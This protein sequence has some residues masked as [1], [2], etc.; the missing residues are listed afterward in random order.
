M[1]DRIFEV[2][3]EEEC[4]ELLAAH[5]FGRIGVV[6]GGAPVILPVN[7]VFHEG[8]IAIRTDRGTKLSA[9]A[10]AQV[11]FEIDSADDVARTGWSVLIRGTGYDVTDSVDEISAHLRD[12]FV[13]TWAPGDHANLVRVEPTSITGRRIRNGG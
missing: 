9:A 11:A 3:S 7:Y 4:R 1:A 5:H 6:S 13:D 10:L 2:L 8:R 12:T